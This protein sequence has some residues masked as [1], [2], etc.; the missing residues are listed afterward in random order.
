MIILKNTIAIIIISFFPLAILAQ[1]AND[2]ACNATPI[3]VENTGC[4]PTTT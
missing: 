3:A 2:D 4:E 1:P